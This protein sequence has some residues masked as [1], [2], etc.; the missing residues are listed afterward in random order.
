MHTIYL[1][2]GSNMGERKENIKKAILFVSDKVQ[3][4]KT[5]HLYES[6]AVGYED[7]PNFL[8]TVVEGETAL[9]PEDLLNFIKEVEKKVGRVETFHW[10]PR[11]IDIDIIFYDDLIFK[12]EIL[13]IPHKEIPE[14]DFVLVPLCEIAPDLVHPVLKKTIKALAESMTEAE[15]S[16]LAKIDF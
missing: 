6:K 3:I 11:V 7:Q 12:N 16:I 2:L 15:M 14:R 13:E 1:A 10:G 8:N 4:L 9:L 5:A